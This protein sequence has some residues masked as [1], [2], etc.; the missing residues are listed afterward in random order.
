[1]VLSPRKYFFI[2]LIILFCSF[3]LFSDVIILKNG[4]EIEG[5]IKEEA[6][7][8][9]NIMTKEKVILQIQKNRIKKIIKKEF[10]FPETTPLRSPIATTPENTDE[11]I[12]KAKSLIDKLNHKDAER[13][14]EKA[15]KI[16]PQNPE[17][18][19]LLAQSYEYEEKQ[20]LAYDHY[21]KAISL[22]KEKYLP[23]SLK[24]L[25]KIS[26][27]LINKYISEKKD[28]LALKILISRIE[29]LPN[30]FA[31]MN[32]PE[33]DIQTEADKYYLAGLISLKNN[34][35]NLARHAFKKV[36][37]I[38]PENKKAQSE[39]ETSFSNDVTLATN[40]FNDRNFKASRDIIQKI[41]SFYPNYK[42]ANDLL[43]LIETEEKAQ[44]EYEQLVETYKKKNY[45][46]VRSGIS[47][48]QSSYPRT[49]IIPY[50]DA[51]YKLSMARIKIINSDYD[52][53]IKFCTD[54]SDLKIKDKWLLEE[55]QIVVNIAQ[56]RKKADE[57]LK[58]GKEYLET[59]E[60]DKAIQFFDDTIKKY[61]DT[62][63]SATALELKNK[64]IADKYWYEEEIRIK[65]IEEQKTQEE[66]ERLRPKVGNLDGVVKVFKDNRTGT[67]PDSNASITIVPLSDPQQ[68]FQT[69]T[70][71]NGNYNFENLPIGEY[72]ITCQFSIYN[73]IKNLSIIIEDKKT[74]TLDFYWSKADI[75][76][77]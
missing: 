16:E 55:A 77:L 53:A 35:T 2:I 57:I 33:L 51:L 52:E 60:F 9:V 69:T 31:N 10:T 73:K 37:E 56:E 28:D 72:K 23:L 20:K 30:K 71:S 29:I 58:E 40:Y 7:D 75:L 6:K 66:A 19:Y 76:G 49:T 50:A 18:H 45:E 44:G 42:S 43:K 39:L 61:P 22:N 8:F 13:Y 38:D 21:I 47:Y 27:V 63:T 68:S 1:M 74:K 17:A 46:D 5:V 59:K 24:N 12:S 41:L 15:I 32:I 36:L 65:K 11:L 67:I 34:H 48:L 26:D 64:A 3:L 62:Y 4:T 70:D 25:V 14:L 54:I